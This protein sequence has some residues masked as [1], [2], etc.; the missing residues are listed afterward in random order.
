MNR[1]DSEVAGGILGGFRPV[2][3]VMVTE[4]GAS[5]GG[6][7][8][9]WRGKE[10]RSGDSVHRWTVGRKREEEGEGAAWCRRVRERGTGVDVFAGGRRG[11]RLKFAGGGDRRKTRE[12]KIR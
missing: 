2:E 3:G 12:R 11:W 8:R 1:P 9:Q 10:R 6:D 4:S 7:A 5:Y